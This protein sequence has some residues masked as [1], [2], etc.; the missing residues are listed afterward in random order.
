MVA[1]SGYKNHI[2]NGDQKCDFTFYITKIIIKA[3][4]VISKRMLIIID[5]I[6]LL[7]I[8]FTILSPPIFCKIVG[9]NHTSNNNLLSIEHSLI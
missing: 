9:D 1:I 3:N 6:K 5:I 2:S 4:I 8:I 7:N